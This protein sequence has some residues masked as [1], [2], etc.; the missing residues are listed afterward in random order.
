MANIIPYIALYITR[1]QTA[2]RSAV[3]GGVNGR[4]HSQSTPFMCHTQYGG[5]D[6]R[7]MIAHLYFVH[8]GLPACTCMSSELLY[9]HLADVNKVTP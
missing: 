8:A 9:R 7:Q 5:V 6:L 2:V 1:A 3:F 4:A